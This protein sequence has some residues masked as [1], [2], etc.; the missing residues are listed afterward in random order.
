MRRRRSGAP[1]RRE[2]RPLGGGRWRSG[3]KGFALQRT[4]PIDIFGIVK[5]G[6]MA[7][8]GAG[9]YAPGAPLSVLERRRERLSVGKLMDEG[10]Y[11]EAMEKALF[12]KLLDKLDADAWD[13]CHQVI[14]LLD[15]LSVI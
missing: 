13:D 10:K 6:L 11:L 5:R 9:P 3:V 14:G 8:P 7:V 4:R 1:D 2:K 15:G 12:T